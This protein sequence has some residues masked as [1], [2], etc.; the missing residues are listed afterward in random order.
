M[1]IYILRICFLE[2]FYFG[3]F[4]IWKG[5]Q[6]KVLMNYVLILMHPNESLA[7]PNGNI[8]YS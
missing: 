3:V 7:C 6:K 2:Y 5:I 4:L 8:D 1:G